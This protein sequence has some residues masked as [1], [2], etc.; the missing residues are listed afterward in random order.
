MIGDKP[1]S[2]AVRGSQHC[3]NYLDGIYFSVKEFTG[4]GRNVFPSSEDVTSHE[5]GNIQ[6]HRLSNEPRGR[7]QA[8][9]KER[10]PR[11]GKTLHQLVPRQLPGYLELTVLD[12]NSTGYSAADRQ[13]SESE[14]RAEPIDQRRTQRHIFSKFIV[15]TLA[16][17]VDHIPVL[18]RLAFLAS[19]LPN[20]IG[21][22]EI[23]FTQEHSG[24]V[25]RQ[26]K[27]WS[28]KAVSP[29]FTPF[30]VAIRP[31]AFVPSIGP[32]YDIEQRFM[33]WKDPPAADTNYSVVSD[34]P[35]K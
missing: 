35:L 17:N 2:R 12:F 11:P 5:Y 28:A 24:Q 14:L 34:E 18:W 20:P 32:K 9:G 6:A 7:I 26:I 3:S 25:S 30:N 22:F 1:G 27:L 4:I 10:N 19:N 16:A 21:I 33:P 15:D 29:T 8:V 13:R 23:R 31:Y